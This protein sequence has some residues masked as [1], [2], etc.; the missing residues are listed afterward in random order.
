M[1]STSRLA[2]EKGY[3]KV[4]EEYKA[5]E[6]ENRE[7][8]AR[9]RLC[10]RGRNAHVHARKARPTKTQSRVKAEILYLLYS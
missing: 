7:L 10:E 3:S 2:R 9:R 6:A 5:V 4:S 8:V 1:V